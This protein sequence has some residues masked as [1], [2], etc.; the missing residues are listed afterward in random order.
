MKKILMLILSF[1][2]VF[3][4]PGCTNGEESEKKVTTP[5]SKEEIKDKVLGGWIGHA[6]GMGSGFEYVVSSNN[7]S[8][9]EKSPVDGVVVDGYTAIVALSDK[10]WEP[11]GQVCAGSIG[12]NP[13]KIRPI[14][15]PR[16]V[17]G[18]VYSD[19]DMHVDILNQFIFRDYG[20]NIG[21]NDIANAWKYYDV[22]DVGGGESTRSLVN[23]SNF[24]PPYTGQSTYGNVGYWVTESW[25]ENETLGMT[26]PYMYATSEAYADLFTQVQGDAYAYYLGKLSALMYTLA[27]EY[28]D[29]KLILEKAF[30]KIGKSNELYDIYQYVLKCYNSGVSWRQACIG[31]VERAVNCAQIR[32]HDMAGF[33]I[34]A[35]AGMIFLGLIYGENDFEESIKITSLAGLDGDCTAATVGGILGMIYGYENLPE[36][37]KKFLPKESVYYNH[38][39]SNS[40]ATG[41]SW[42]AFAYMGKN[43]PNAI[44][45]EWLTNLT[46]S[47]IENQIIARGGNVDKA[48]GIYNIA[49]QE[50]KAIPSVEVKNYSFED[51][52]TDNW[53]FETDSESTF[54]ASLS[55]VHIGTYGGLIILDDI[56][57]TANVYQSLQLEVGHTYK[58]SLWVNGATDRAFK[59]FA[60]AGNKEFSRTYVNPLTLSNR[61]M[62]AELIFT[63]TSDKMNI[64]FGILEALED[65]YT[66]TFSIDDLFVDDITHTVSKKKSQVFEAEKL[67]LNSDTEIVNNKNASGKKEVLLAS[68]GAITTNFEGEDTYQSFKLYYSN[69]SG[70]MSLVTI[71]IDGKKVCVLPLVA[72]GENYKFNEGNYAEMLLYIGKGS[73]KIKIVYDSF[74]ELSIDKLV[75]SDGNIL[76]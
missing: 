65:S 74:D 64:G 10:Y 19:D 48:N 2:F 31:I 59:I 4:I 16:I 50:Y 25:I 32:I 39:G 69:K 73:H 53:Q 45:F 18:K 14:S 76:S 51:G 12:V 49:V 38:T 43:F 27:Y 61:H 54:S 24:I 46:L 68:G 36:K 42:G 37:Y 57:S 33:S 44:T 11:D 26:F 9:I 7:W 22:H 58:V 47:N 23:N 28:D 62:K 52:T 55:A 56:A 66:T 29:A 3:S 13:Y 1:L 71:Y 8:E 20:P 34:N 70:M 40:F 41:V 75:I 60:Q 67:T 21:A 17:Q 35:N 6:I 72:N 5:F 63:A 30:D 15:D